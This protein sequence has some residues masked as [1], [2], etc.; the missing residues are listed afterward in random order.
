MQLISDTINKE[1]Q[2]WHVLHAL[3][4]QILSFISQLEE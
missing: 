1:L 2:K 3:L 4:Q